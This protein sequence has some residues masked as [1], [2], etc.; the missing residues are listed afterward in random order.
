[1]L[2]KYKKLR[3]NATIPIKATKMSGGLDVVAA[4]IECSI[5]GLFTV[6]TG[7]AMQ[8]PEGYMIRM[9]PR[10]SFTKYAWALNNSPIL[11]DPDYTGEY[12]LQFQPLL[13][14]FVNRENGEEFIGHEN[15]PYKVGDR[16]AQMWLEKIHPIEFEEGELENITDRIGGFGSTGK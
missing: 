8:P 16:V 2:I 11:G 13:A 14:K 12:I 4:H 6:Y 1:M 7:L 10:S 9:S 5:D 15:F 3:E